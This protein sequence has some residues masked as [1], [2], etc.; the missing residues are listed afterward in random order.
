[1]ITKIVEQIKMIEIKQ[2]SYFVDGGMGFC[3]NW[4]K[5][6]IYYKGIYTTPEDVQKKIKEAKEHWEIERE[7][8]WGAYNVEIKVTEWWENKE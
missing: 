8:R 4:V 7:K 2:P 3:G 5:E 1:M 6:H